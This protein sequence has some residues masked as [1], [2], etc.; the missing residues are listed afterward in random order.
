M[1]SQMQTNCN[2]GIVV[3]VPTVEKSFIDL[4]YNSQ[5]LTSLKAELRNFFLENKSLT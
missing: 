2:D 4:V 5:T 1:P 3:P